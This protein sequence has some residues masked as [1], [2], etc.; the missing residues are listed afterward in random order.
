MVRMIVWL[1]RIWTEADDNGGKPSWSRVCATA[2][3]GW[4]CWMM[5]AGRPIP[6][7]G[8]EIAWGLILYPLLSKLLSRNPILLEYIKLRFAALQGKPV[9]PQG[10]PPP[11]NG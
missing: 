9:I 2:Y 8:E 11:V 1:G 6:S 3:L 7:I 5:T 10:N 4:L